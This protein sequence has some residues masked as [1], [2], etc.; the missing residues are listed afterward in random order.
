MEKLSSAFFQRVMTINAESVVRLLAATRRKL[1]RRETDIT[2]SAVFPSVSS[3]FVVVSSQAGLVA[4]ADN[5][6]YSAS[7]FALI[8]WARSMRS[9]LASEGVA[10]RVAAPGCTVTPLFLSAQAEFAAA[11]GVTTEAFLQRRLDR[12]PV[13]RFASTTQTAAV[14]V[15]LSAPVAD[16]PFLLAATGGETCH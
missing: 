3:S 9:S 15:Y 14:I 13:G 2:S 11:T 5:A 7:K 16:R 6:A 12:I 10:I 4:E 1:A 8:G